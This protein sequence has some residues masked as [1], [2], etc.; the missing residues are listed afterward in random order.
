MFGHLKPQDFIDAA[1]SGLT[2]DSAEAVKRAAHLRSCAPCAAQLRATT[3]V[4]NDLAC[5]NSSVPEPDWSDFR[6]SVR[7]EL[8]SRSIQRQTTVRRWTGWAVG[9]ATAWTVAFALLL[10]VSVGGFLWHVQQDSHRLVAHNG[11]Q[12]STETPE[13]E[14]LGAFNLAGTGVFQQ[15]S[16]LEEPQV[17]RLQDLI[18]STQKGTVNVQ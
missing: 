12:N 1:E 15:L 7:I 17:E 9:P 2:T 14:D 11:Q 18:E 13:I 4:R 3:A 10:A 5:E 8:L 16:D 6:E